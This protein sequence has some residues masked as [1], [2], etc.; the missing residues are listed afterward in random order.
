M[1]SSDRVILHAPLTWA[2]EEFPKGFPQLACFL[3]SDEA[4]M[5]YCRFGTVFARLLLSKQ[6]EI[7]QLE[8]KL[9]AM[10]KTDEKNGD[11]QYLMSRTLDDR[12]SKVDVPPTWQN[13]TRRDV[14]AKLEKLTLDYGLLP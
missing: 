13:E 2:V 12:R 8:A 5:I 11:S 1:S 10:D 14:L 3:D 7:S 6:D 9:H 4:F